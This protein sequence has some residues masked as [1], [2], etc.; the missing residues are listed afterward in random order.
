MNEFI[1]DDRLDMEDLKKNIY[2]MTEEELKQYLEQIK[3]EE[4]HSVNDK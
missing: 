1:C 4:E 3:M 2:S